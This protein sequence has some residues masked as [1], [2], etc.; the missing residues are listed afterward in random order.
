MTII[1]TPV[2]HA[3]PRKCLVCGRRY[4]GQSKPKYALDRKGRIR[5]TAHAT[6]HDH[7]GKM[8]ALGLV[9]Y[10]GNYATTEREAQLTF[11]LHYAEF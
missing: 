5:G 6:C 9:A 7:K 4:G 10:C 1:E 3:L 8:E 2:S 11:F